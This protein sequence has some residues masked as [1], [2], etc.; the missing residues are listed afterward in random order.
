M[1]KLKYHSISKSNYTTGA[2]ETYIGNATQNVPNANYYCYTQ[3][4]QY[5]SSNSIA[6]TKSP[7]MKHC[8]RENVKLT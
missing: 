6:D 3:P 7:T 2:D 1:N 5:K 8:A 4:K